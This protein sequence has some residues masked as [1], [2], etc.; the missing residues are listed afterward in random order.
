MSYIA[1]SRTFDSGETHVPYSCHDEG[2]T[3]WISALRRSRLG[4]LYGSRTDRR[5]EAD[6]RGAQRPRV[7]RCRHF[8]RLGQYVRPVQK[9]MLI[10]RWQI[11]PAKRTRRGRPPREADPEVGSRR[12]G[13]NADKGQDRAVRC[14]GHEPPELLLEALWHARGLL[15]R[16]GGEAVLRLQHS[17]TGRR[18]GVCGR[19]QRKHQQRSMVRR[20]PSKLG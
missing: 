19:Q 11:R 13:R 1:F 12:A 6:W 17:A 5:E 4:G 14:A 3:A 15:R 9:F 8:G 10:D 16:Q 20:R 2:Y 7:R 18:A